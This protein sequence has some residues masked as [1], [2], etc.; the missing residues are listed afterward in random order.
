[1]IKKSYPPEFE[2]LWKAY[3]K[4]QGK[5]A[6]YRAFKRLKITP[7]D[8]EQLIPTV[9]KHKKF[10]ESEEREQRFIPSLGPWLNQ[11]RFD[12]VIDLPETRTERLAREEQE[13]AERRG[14]LAK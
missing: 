10:W 9:E 8:V 1:M 2:K 14:R 7:I 3:T 13:T 11:G 4:K 6:A 5:D 12:D